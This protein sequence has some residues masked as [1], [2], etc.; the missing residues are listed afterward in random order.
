MKREAIA[1]LLKE[2][3]ICVHFTKKDGTHRT[4]KC[5]LK[6]DLLP[7]VESTATSTRKQPENSL[8]VFDL[9]ANGWRS[10]VIDSVKCI[11]FNTG[12]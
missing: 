1:N 12:V 10:F 8:A 5:T 3:V 4:M 11:S 6:A 9:E 2:D 7:V